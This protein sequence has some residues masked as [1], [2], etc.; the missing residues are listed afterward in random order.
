MGRDEPGRAEHDMV[1]EQL[2]ALLESRPDGEIVG[3]GVEALIDSPEPG[4]G[5]V[6]I[7][8]P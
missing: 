2:E 4:S 7:S 5:F 6:D 3:I 1:D 8:R